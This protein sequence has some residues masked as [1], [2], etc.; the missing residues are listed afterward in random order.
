[1][2]GRVSELLAILDAKTG[3]PSAKKR[4]RVVQPGAMAK[5]RVELEKTLPLEVPGRVVLRAE[6]NTIAAG[7]LDAVIS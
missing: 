4:P 3:Q 2:A 6:G 5:V 7:L 1:M